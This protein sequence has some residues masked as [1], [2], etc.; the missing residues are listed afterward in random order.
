MN[1]V[2]F[3]RTFFS[4][5][6]WIPHFDVEVFYL[7]FGISSWNFQILRESFM[8]L[9]PK[10]LTY[11]VLIVHW[12]NLWRLIFKF[13][14]CNLFDYENTKLK[15]LLFCM[16]FSFHVDCILNTGHIIQFVLY[17]VMYVSFYANFRF[18]KSESNSTQVQVT[19]GKDYTFSLCI[20]IHVSVKIF[21]FHSTAISCWQR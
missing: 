16:K 13:H 19:N 12:K 15:V 3:K 1:K 5:W 8:N 6:L 20:Y 18:Q 17:F 7:N 2:H 10:N 4:A 11:N 14:I 9:P 21:Y